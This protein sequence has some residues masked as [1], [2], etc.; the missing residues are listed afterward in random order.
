[1]SQLPDW[2]QILPPFVEPSD[3]IAAYWNA[4]MHLV[5]GHPDL[6]D[7][8]FPS[9]FWNA[10]ATGRPVLASGFT[11]V[12]AAELEAARVSNFRDHLRQWKQ[13]VLDHVSHGAP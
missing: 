1:M 4:E 3:C 11:G 7:A 2:I 10:H 6:S 5:A 12:M 9:K 8:V 13:L